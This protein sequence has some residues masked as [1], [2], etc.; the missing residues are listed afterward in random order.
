[1]SVVSGLEDDFEPSL[2]VLTP[3]REALLVRTSEG[4]VLAWDIS[5]DRLRPVRSDDDAVVERELATLPRHDESLG[6]G[7]Q[8]VLVGAVRGRELRKRSVPQIIV[9]P[10][11]G[12][13]LRIYRD[14]KLDLLD[15]LGASV[16][17]IYDHSDAVRTAR[18]SPD[19][20]LVVTA[21]DDGTAR[22]WD[23]ENGA[24]LAVFT[25]HDGAV[26]AV[27]F[28]SD[29]ER[30]AT[31]GADGTIRVFPVTARGMLALACSRVAGTAAWD[32]VAAACAPR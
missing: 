27:A 29:G 14:G 23:A 7:V 15:E 30:I 13:R 32:R 5:R 1:M 26:L 16:A 31:G 8:E 2:L 3:D 19:G 10:R 4:A 11:A 22:L 20:T 18:F 25:G 24:A 28:S 9:S 6:G 12:R 21:G 17:T